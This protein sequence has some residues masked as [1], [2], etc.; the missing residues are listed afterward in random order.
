MSSAPPD[1]SL[2]SWDDIADLAEWQVLLLGNGL[3]VNVWPPFGYRAL[4][5]HAARAELTDEDRALFAGTTNFERVLADLNTAIR[6]AGIAGLPTDKL[7]ARYQSIQ[8]ALGSAV[9]E[10]HLT[11]SE[12]PD[13]SMATIRGVMEGFEWIFTTSYD[14]LV[15]WTMGYGGRYTP[16]V[17][18]FRYGGR[19]EFDSRRA[20][21]YAGKIPVYYLH[22]ALHLVV[23]G[24]GATWK[25]TLSSLETILDQ[26]GKPV[27]GDPQARPL[28]VTEGSSHDK[29]TAIEANRYLSHCLNRLRETALPV[30]VFGSSLSDQDDH[31]VQALNEH[32]SR[33]LAVSMIPGGSKRERARTQVDLWGRLTAETLYFYDA[34]SHPLGGD[35][36]AKLA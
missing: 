35:L 30:V 20:D 12:V 27:A 23:G 14:L 25:L 33:P 32:R 5:D 11:R 3:S 2:Y 16:F 6:V 34:T 21:V 36:A 4:F 19:C 28:L 24:S 8:R 31:L 13:T 7:Y 1:G 15:Y 10:V 26:F 18:H 17:D 9:R 22:G 29:L